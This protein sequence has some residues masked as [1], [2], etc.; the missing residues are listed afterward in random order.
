MPYVALINVQ[1]VTQSTLGKA[2][3]KRASCRSERPQISEPSKEAH[4]NPVRQKEEGLKPQTSWAKHAAAASRSSWHPQ[5]ASYKLRLF[6]ASTLVC[7]ATLSFG[8]GVIS[9]QF[10]RALAFTA[11]WIWV[12]RKK[13]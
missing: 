1:P 8:A 9:N 3:N 2:T 13:A 4:Q 5:N 7:T 11:V 12:Q 6:F 10:A